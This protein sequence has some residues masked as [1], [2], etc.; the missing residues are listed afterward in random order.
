MVRG[1]VGGGFERV[2]VLHEALAVEAEVADSRG[3]RGVRSHKDTADG[4][5]ERL[6]TFDAAVADV[7]AADWR[8][9]F[10]VYD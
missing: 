4:W 7:E 1:A 6:D 9:G 8:S 3:G 10:V 2:E 5:E